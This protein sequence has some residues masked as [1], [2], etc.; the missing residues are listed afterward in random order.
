MKRIWIAF[1]ACLSATLALTAGQAQAAGRAQAAGLAPLAA[2]APVV[3]C[4]SL[5]KLDL[6]GATGAATTLA[7]TE[8]PGDHAFCQVTGTIAPAIQFEVRLPLAG[9]TQRYLQ[10]GCGGLCGSIPPSPRGARL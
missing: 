8:A 7:A 2:V 1:L 4:A 10:T 6:S 5:A 9:W 3:S